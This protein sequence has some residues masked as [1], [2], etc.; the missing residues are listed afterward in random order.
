MI[1]NSNAE[2]ISGSGYKL[3]ADSVAVVKALAVKEGLSLAAKE[4][5]QQLLVKLTTRKSTTA[6]PRKDIPQ[7]G[8][9]NLFARISE[10]WRKLFN[11]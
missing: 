4:H 7:I 3:K 6:Y 5:L 10:T 2:V 11:K 9:S 1:R 8:E